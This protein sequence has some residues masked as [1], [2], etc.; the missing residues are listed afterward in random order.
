MKIQVNTDDHVHGSEELTAS[1]TDMIDSALRR[2]R[3]QIT[4]VEVHMSDENGGKGGPED[5]RCMLEARIEGRKP[6]AVIEHAATMKQAVHGATQ[7][8]VSMLDSTLGRLHEHRRGVQEP[9]G[10]DV[11]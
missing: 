6:A 10:V 8:L 1:V 2:F 11:E 3:E 7:K 9:S 4:R 5:K